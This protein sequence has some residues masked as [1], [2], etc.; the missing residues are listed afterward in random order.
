MRGGF[1]AQSIAPG[2]AEGSP[3]F[4]SVAGGGRLPSPNGSSP[5]SAPTA[6]FAVDR[7]LPPTPLAPA[8]NNGA[9]LEGC[10]VSMSTGTALCYQMELE[11]WH[12]PVALS[13]PEL[14][15]CSREEDR[16]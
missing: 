5:G 2:L 7:V 3:Y 6:H 12:D 16:A 4:H 15:S 8:D 1:W 11:E 10:C 9:S 14:G 13:L